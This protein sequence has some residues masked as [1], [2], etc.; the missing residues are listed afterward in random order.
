M[1]ELLRLYY[2]NLESGCLHMVNIIAIHFVTKSHINIEM[3]F[4][5]RPL[6]AGRHRE[7]LRDE[8]TER[9]KM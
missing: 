2:K 4:V 8:C 7:A 9:L 5:R 3:S 6:N 1:R